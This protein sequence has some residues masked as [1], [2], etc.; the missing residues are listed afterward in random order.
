MQPYALAV[1]PDGAT[2]FVA[3]KGACVILR[4]A[5]PRRSFSPLSRS[6]SS[7]PSP[8]DTHVGK[9]VKEAN[10][11]SKHNEPKHNEPKLVKEPNKYTK[12]IREPN[13][14][15]D[16]REVSGATSL[17]KEPNNYTETYTDTTNYKETKELENPT[18][19]P[20][21][22]VPENPKAEADGAKGPVF[23]AMSPQLLS[24]PRY[25]CR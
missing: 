4:V 15:T 9:D 22:K 16:T 18:D 14:Y 12:I 24:L 6:P 8:P 3:D 13:N 20:K 23:V 17:V 7:P 25:V 11:H 10:K 5:L 1:S 2:M 19:K 21:D